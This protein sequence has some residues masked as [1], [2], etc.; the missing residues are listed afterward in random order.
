MR[1]R[2]V[3]GWMIVVPLRVRSDGEPRLTFAGIEKGMRVL[4]PE[5]GSGNIAQAI[6]DF[7]DVL[8]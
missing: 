8:R 6:H 7:I 2:H 3:A 1:L 4:E 5:G